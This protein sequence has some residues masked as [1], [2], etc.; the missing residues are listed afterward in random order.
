[1]SAPLSELIRR[2]RAL[3]E[4]ITQLSVEL[5]ALDRMIFP[6]V[7][8]LAEAVEG[9]AAGASSARSSYT[10]AGA[11]MGPGG[12]MVNAHRMVFGDSRELV[13]HNGVRPSEGALDALRS[14]VNTCAIEPK[15]VASAF[16]E[17]NVVSAAAIGGAL[18]SITFGSSSA[19]AIG[20]ALSGASPLGIV[21]SAWSCSEHRGRNHG[22]VSTVA[23]AAFAVL[24]KSGAPMK[25]AFIHRS[26]LEKGIAVRGKNPLNNLSAHLS[27]DERFVSTPDGW[28]I[29]S[30]SL[31]FQDADEPNL[32]QTTWRYPAQNDQD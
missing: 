10:S 25:T 27:N 19:L 23:N 2:R 1:M 7:A 8:K 6:R 29:R 17:C 4:R 28:V 11:G 5:D 31:R 12:N 15:S 24:Q 26:L 22:I 21:G 13:A 14:K 30:P 9:P 20:G 3:K 18:S 16:D 32:N